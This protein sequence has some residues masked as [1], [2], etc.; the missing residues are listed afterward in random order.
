MYTVICPHCPPDNN[1]R[2]VYAKKK[3]MKDQ[4]EPFV[5]I[6]KSCVQKGKVK[7]E[8]HKKKLSDAVKKIQTKELREKKRKFMLEHPEYWQGNLQ[9]GNPVS[10]PGFTHTE[11]TKKKI[12]EGVSKSMKSKKENN[13]E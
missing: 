6:C 8:E 10:N 4:K 1:I 7:T 12:G 5:Y 2:V 9:I 3:W 11:E 13:N